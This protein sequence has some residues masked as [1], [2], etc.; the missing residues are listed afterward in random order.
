MDP[1]TTVFDSTFVSNLDLHEPQHLNTLFN[2]LGDQGKAYLMIRSLGFESPVAGDEYHHWEEERYHDYFQQYAGASAG[3][4]EA[5]ASATLILHPDKISA[6]GKYYVRRG[7]EIICPNETATWVESITETPD[8]FGAGIPKVE[9]VIKPLDESKATGVIAANTKLGIFTGISSEGAGMPEPVATGAF[10]VTNEAQIVKE[11]IGVTGTELVNATRFPVYNEAG[12]VQGWYRQGQKAMD[13]RFLLKMDGLFWVGNRVVGTVSPSRV[14]DPTSGYRYKGSDGLIPSLRARG[15]TAPYTVGSF[16]FDSEFESYDEI[17]Q[18]EHVSSDTPLWMPMAP[19]LYNEVEK[20][21]VSYLANTNINY[22]RQS[23]D[24]TLFKGNEAL[25]IS[26]AFTYAQIKGRTFLFH[27][28]N[29]FASD[30]TFGLAGY[31]YSK[32]GF[33][34]PLEKGIDPK[35][36]N[37]IPSIGT[38]YRAMG[39]YNRRLI[40]D[41]LSGVGATPGGGI[42]VHTIDKSNTYMMAHMGNEFFGLNRMIL[43]DPQE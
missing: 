39:A 2:G 18:R 9:V 16:D 5:G 12:A 25:G 36:K 35:T 43:I 6:D 38:R 42:A 10:K 21:A 19:K 24:N 22:T 31:K 28:L 1:I 32:M 29:G 17:L 3:S 15:N 14:I 20:E 27:K 8:F 11:S 30:T 4:A 26:V 7:D 13:Y 33:V 23:V 34:I 37:S 41:Q 40:T